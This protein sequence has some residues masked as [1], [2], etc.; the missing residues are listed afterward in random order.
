ELIDEDSLETLLEARPHARVIADEI[1]RLEKEIEKIEGA[2]LGF[3]GFIRAHADA[4]FVPQ[5]RGKVGIGVRLKTSQSVLQVFARPRHVLAQDAATV[6]PAAPF[7]RVLKVPIVAELDEARP[8][9]L[10][11]ARCNRF[12]ATDLFRESP[13]RPAV[14]VQSF[15]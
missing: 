2:G 7:A 13:R 10:V 15:I 4:E 3:R 5:C 14:L 12:G 9:P 8:E 6:I 1:S 11:V